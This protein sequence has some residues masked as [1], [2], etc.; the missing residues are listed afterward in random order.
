MVT[1]H[2][3]TWFIIH[4]AMD[5]LFA[6][7]LLLAPVFTMTLFGWTTIDPTTTRLVGAALLAIGI[8]SYLGR[9]AS[10]EVFE[11]MLNL[12]IIWSG[13]VV[14]SIIFTLVSG[15]PPMAWIFLAIFGMFFVVWVYF[16]LKIGAAAK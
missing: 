13:S 9:N 7:P 4:F 6:I 16:R 5:M 15:A 14:V 8:E 11:A 10:A 2:L 12:K 3:R 1:K